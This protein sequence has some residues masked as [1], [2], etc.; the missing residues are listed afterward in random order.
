MIVKPNGVYFEGSI[1]DS[2]QF[3]GYIRNPVLKRQSRLDKDPGCSKRIVYG[4]NEEGY[5]FMN[6]ERY[7]GILADSKRR[8]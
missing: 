8:L 4:A 3:R 7:K 1:Q 6:G 2:D 5:V